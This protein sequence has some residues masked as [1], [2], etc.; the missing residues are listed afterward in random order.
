MPDSASS[1]SRIAELDGL[2]GLAIALVYVHHFVIPL[3][4]NAPGSPGAYVAAA[5]TLT[6]TGVDLFFVL[7]GFLIGGILLDHRDSPALLRTFYLRR[8]ARIVP[9]AL[10]CILAVLGA[11]AAGLYGPAEGREPWAWPVYA[12][13]MTNLWMAGTLDWGYRPLAPLWSLGIEEQFYLLTPGLVRLVSRKNILRLLLTFVGLAPLLR[14]G[15]MAINR[16]WSFAASLLPFG[17]MDC[18][19]AGFVVAW[20]VR[21]AVVRAWGD[22]HQVALLGCL[23]PAAAGL[24]ILTRLHAGNASP[25]M[26]AGGYTV[27]ALFYGLILLLT[28]AS[29]GAAWTRLLRWAPLVQL[30]R[31]SYF[32]YLFQGLATGLTVGLLFH[33]RLAVI[34]PDNWLQL[35]TGA[36]GLLL[37]AA[38]S[39]KFF[40]A[41]LVRWGQRHSY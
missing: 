14:L 32:V 23:L 8:F 36:A 21:A 17:R 24:A 39:W 35:V 29:P 18:I 41:P 31:W 40:E 25:P 19:G 27:T 22:R 30:G 33:H 3:C 13:F 5:L 2:R 16:D 12:L 10:L 15:L 9:L 38:L 11:Q 34:A 6:Y 20:L 1:Q 37:A 7:S 4:G 26:A 28:L